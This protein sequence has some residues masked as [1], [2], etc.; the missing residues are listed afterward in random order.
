MN[1]GWYKHLHNR[2]D[3]RR[4]LLT[5]RAILS[6]NLII[7]CVSPSQSFADEQAP[8]EIIDLNRWKLTLPT[9]SREDGYANEL[10]PNEL[11]AFVDPKHF[12]VRDNAIVFRAPC[13]GATTKGSSYPRCELREMNDQ[14]ELAGWN[15]TG[16]T[17]HTMSVRL[18]ITKTPSVK[19]HVVCAQIHDE[20]N[21]LLMIRLE[22]KKLFLER[23]PESDVMLD[24]N[25]QLGT[26]VDFKIQA[27][28]GRIKV[29]HEGDVKLNW[30]VSR[31]G[32]YFKAGCYTQSNPNKGDSPDTF[33][34][35]VIS[36]LHI[37]HE[38]KKPINP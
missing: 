5:L 28:N 26:F 4:S 24:R 7:L 32:C 31:K 35:V 14:S 3:T 12:F 36:R 15:T 22:G 8:S 27:F 1:N 10:E 18:A 21:D 13:G 19:R 20:K 33:G 38:S 37:S 29:W 9:T 17:E 23:K 6:L 16:F 34:E 25:Y 2:C 11:A 30:D